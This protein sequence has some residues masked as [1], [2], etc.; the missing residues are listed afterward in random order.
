M[1]FPIPVP[2]PDHGA[3]RPTGVR[4]ATLGVAALL[5]ATALAA[6]PLTAHAQEAGASEPAAEAAVADAASVEAPGDEPADPSGSAAATPEPVDHVAPVEPEAPVPPAA[7]RE[8]AAPVQQD[9]AAASA[10]EPAEAGPAN[11]A[12]LAV[13]DH[14]SMTQGEVLDVPAPGFLANDS[15]PDGDPLVGHST[16]AEPGDG[17][18]WFPYGGA[19]TYEP[20]PAFTGTYVL[21]YSIRDDSGAV[22]NWATITIEVL[23]SDDQVAPVVPNLGPVATDDTY[24]TPMGTPLTV[25]SPGVL[26][27]DSDP[28]GDPLKVQGHQTPWHGWLALQ[29]DGSMTYT[30]KP[31]FAGTDTFS[32]GAFDG[33][34]Y[35]WADITVEVTPIAGANTAPIAEDDEFTAVAG[36]PFII[37]DLGL[38]ANDSDADGDPIAITA[39]TQAPVFGSIDLA[40][41]GSSVTYTPGAGHTGTDEFR[42]EISDGEYTDTA[43][44]V[45]T[46]VAPE[47]P[48]APHPTGTDRLA[49]AAAIAVPAPECEPTEPTQP[50]E[51][52]EPAE[53]TQP[54]EPAEPVVHHADPARPAEPRTAGLP[55]STVALAEAGSDTRLAIALAAMITAL[56]LVLRLG[57]RKTAR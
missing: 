57:G 6:A 48:C 42:Y 35:S 22:S 33:E 49:A 53:P 27:N 19:F 11:G 4:V 5:A 36:S 39:I 44:V 17:F 12:P 45:I 1:R 43:R 52:T 2:E 14:Y 38:L 46:T 31:G 10:P 21:A 24:S 40:V 54:S 56:G 9:A 37:G 8:I 3:L 26:G 50:A 55:G 16:D 18:G 32:Y 30:P 34:L 13:D 20:D 47:D 41:D 29:A 15:D 51:P 25:P 28:D 7:P 23:P